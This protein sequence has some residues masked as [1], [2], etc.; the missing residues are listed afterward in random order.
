MTIPVLR[1]NQY[2]VLYTAVK[3]YI[4][5]TAKYKAVPLQNVELNQTF[6]EMMK[7]LDD[8]VSREN[9]KNQTEPS[10]QECYVVDKHNEV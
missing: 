10:T 8:C 1:M 3:K 6:L 4:V 2:A 5:A 7:T 9:D